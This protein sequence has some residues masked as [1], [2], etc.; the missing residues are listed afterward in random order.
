VRRNLRTLF[1]WP[2]WGGTKNPLDF[3]SVDGMTAPPPNPSGTYGFGQGLRLLSLWLVLG[4]ALWSPDLL[5]VDWARVQSPG[6]L[7]SE[8][9]TGGAKPSTDHWPKVSSIVAD[10]IETQHYLRPTLD[11]HFSRRALERYFE[12]LDPDRLC[13]LQ[14]DLEEFRSRFGLSFAGRL[15]AG[16]LGPVD[17]IHERFRQRLERY[18]TTAAGIAG[19]EWDFSSPWDVEL[20]REHSAWPADEAEAQNE[21]I[22]QVGADLLGYRLEGASPERA[23]MQ[24]RRR[25]EN[26]AKSVREDGRKE[27]LAAALLAL[28][29]AGDAHSD[30]LTQE[31]L[32]DTESE[33]R[34]TRTG[35]GVSL[36]SDPL[37]LRVSALLPGGPAQRDGRLRVND[38]IV[39]VAEENG[40]FR[41]LEGLPM[42]QALA[43]L[44]GRKGALVRLRVAPSRGADPAQRI[45]LGLR[46]EEL[47]SREG[48]AYAK[49]IEIQN[50]DGSPGLRE[51]WLVV[52]GFYGDDSRPVERRSSSVSRDVGLLL[53]RFMSEKVDGVVLDMRG[54]LGGLL[55]E[56]IE[57]GGLFCG[58]V[59]I[60]AVR[61][62]DADLE[63]LSPIR[64]RGR[65]ALYGGP[66]VVLTDRNSASASEL[67]AGALQDYGRAV[68]VGGEQTF[69]KGSVQ[70]TIPLA[71]YFSVRSKPPVGGV[72]LTVG[73]FYRVSGQ[74]TQLLGVRPDIVLPSTLDLPQEGEAALTDP[75]AHDAIPPFV[76]LQPGPVTIA[77]LTGLRDCSE[78]R[79]QQTSHFSAIMSERDQLRKERR[80]NRLSLKE[81]VRRESLDAVR[82]IYSEREASMKT[83]LEGVRFARMLLEDVRGKRLRFEPADPLG[84]RDPESLTVEREVVWILAD[85]VRATKSAGAPVV[86]QPK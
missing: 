6:P 21:W 62:P 66:L 48:E 78:Q 35:I 18:C 28:A 9:R 7:K 61:S 3:S 4:S 82:R 14:P 67:V 40:P 27:R 43:L 55:D 39:A 76:A 71:E 24:L 10:V 1:R 16:D 32:E 64:V 77:L 68:L 29:R 75:L 56:A 84:S 45:V 30:Y 13:L 33:L 58:R 46:R 22:A 42:S 38:R 26:L 80:E 52:P 53:K 86:T 79:V 72:A 49:I 17:A 47:R 19:G 23:V 44:R 51:G 11:F 25:L 63:V 54:N 20:S 59:P 85:L 69:G 57:L 81:E 73:K 15:K 8:V 12:I 34:L 41:E 37:G 2:E 83:T 60:A 5:G 36:D 70:T 31:E 74:S 50:A 65:Q